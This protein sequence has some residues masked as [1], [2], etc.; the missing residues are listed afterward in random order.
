MN[1]LYI[2]KNRHEARLLHSELLG[3]RGLN[4]N[5]SH[6][7]DYREAIDAIEQ[8]MFATI[9]FRSDDSFDIFSLELREIL[10]SAN[11]PPVVAIGQALNEDQQ[12]RLVLEGLDECLNQ[13]ETTGVDVMRRLRMAELRRSVVQK[14]AAFILDEDDETMLGE[15]FLASSHSQR[16]NFDTNNPLESRMQVA[17]VSYRTPLVA[18]DGN[19]LPV[20]LNAFDSLESLLELLQEDACRFDALLLEQSA[21]EDA[22]GEAANKLIRYL[23]VIPSIVLTHEKSDFSALSY[24]E[25]GYSDC[26]IARDDSANDV[27]LAIRKAVIRR[28]RNLLASISKQQVGPNVNDRRTKVRSSPN[29]RRHVRFYFQQPVIAIPILPDGG[30]DHAG[31]CEATSIDISLR[32]IGLEIPNRDQLPRRNWI[33]GVNQPNGTIGYVNGFLRRINYVEQGMHAGMVFQS[34][35]DDF[36]VPERLQPRIDPRTKQLDTPT[37]SK[38]LDQWAEL[39]V[40]TKYLVQ[41]VRT[42]PECTAVCCVANGCSQCG[43]FHLQFHDLIHHFA[44]AYVGPAAEFEHHQ[45]TQCPK[46]RRSN[47][48]VG[49]DFEIIR[50]K[51]TCLSCDFHGDVT[52]QVGCCLNCRLRF[53][54]DLGPEHDVFGYDVERLD[55]LAVVDAAR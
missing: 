32:G 22:S 48:V 41:K 12:L 5:L 55:I 49:A 27:A 42:C 3:Y 38:Q 43:A 15:A 20:T 24:L 29:R 19:D 2:D 44:C 16:F 23:S 1:I 21:F 9:L 52:T 39:G 28:R 14:H 46:C 36:F 25:R 18:D 53:P 54:L 37:S 34:K 30:P 4:W 8:T 7:D 6:C 17:H 33:L 11:C 10:Q 47:L 40:L 13:A 26:L 35:D 45:I 50:S 51:Y 31:R